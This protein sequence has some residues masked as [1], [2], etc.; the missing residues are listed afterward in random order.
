MGKGKDKNYVEE[1]FGRS[2]ALNGVKGQYI[3]FY[4]KG[5]SSDKANHYVEIQV[6]GK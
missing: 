5:N 2:F 3:R 1:Y 4:S 6:Y